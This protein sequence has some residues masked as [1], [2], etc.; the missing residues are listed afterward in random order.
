MSVPIKVPD[1]G[2]TTDEVKLVRWLVA[3]GATVARGEVLA[4][5]ETDKATVELESTAEG[6]LLRLVAEAG[7]VAHRGDILAYVGRPGEAAPEEAQVVSAPIGA[8]GLER[9]SESAPTGERGAG[10]PVRV[11]PVVR[12]LAAKLGVDLDTVQGTGQGGII[13]REDVLGASRDR[14]PV[15]TPPAPAPPTK[16]E[17]RACA[18]PL[19]PGEVTW[20]ELPRAQGGVARAVT[21][22]WQQIPH[23]RISAAIDMTAAEDLRAQSETDGAKISYDALFLKALAHA[24]K[25]VPLVAARLEGERILW[26]S[27][28]HIALVVGFEEDLLLPVIRDVD[29]KN[30]AALQAEIAD[31]ASKVRVGVLKARQV[32]G[33]CMALSN[34]GMYPIEDFDAII[35]PEHSAILA[36]GAVRKKPVVV[37]GQVEV[38]PVLTAKLAADHRLINGRTAARF[39]SA[40]KEI[41]ESGDLGRG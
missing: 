39:L 41:M 8:R 33:G 1:L 27:G 11:S 28:V 15:V 30:L 29:Q 14:V 24:I 26:P 6:V 9:T 5:I 10:K 12:N 4:E 37:D 23:L 40:V 19:F 17:E 18:P 36:I 20:A 2:T 7:K 38:R 31:L 21:R 16:G 35:F 22:S 25:A 13:T 3:E 34:L 32:T